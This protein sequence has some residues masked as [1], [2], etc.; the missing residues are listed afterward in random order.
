MAI[1]FPLVFINNHIRVRLFVVA[2]PSLRGEL[3][4]AL[5]IYIGD[6]HYIHVRPFCCGY[7]FTTWR[8]C[9]LYFSSYTFSGEV[10][11]TFMFILFVVANG[12]HVAFNFHR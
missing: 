4:Y 12:P 11:Y 2:T 1:V 10:I 7:T 9:C 8:L 5:Y 3:V 6:V